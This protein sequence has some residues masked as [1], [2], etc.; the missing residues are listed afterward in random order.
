MS[1]PFVT[2]HLGAGRHSVN[3]EKPLRKLCKAS[4]RHGMEL[5]NEGKSSQEVAIEVCKLLELSE[6]TN[7]GYGS[8]LNFDGEVECDAGIMESS[9][10]LGASVC[11][12][13]GVTNPIEIAG[14]LLRDLQNEEK[15]PL[16]RVRPIMLVGRGAEKYAERKGIEGGKDLIS[17]SALT[18]FLTWRDIYKKVMSADLTL[19]AEGVQ[20]TEQDLIQDTVGVICGDINGII[21]VATSS[22]GTTLKTPGRVGPAAM[23]G[24]GLNITRKD[25]RTYAVCISG[26]GEDIIQSQVARTLCGAAMFSDI[27]LNQYLTRINEQHALQRPPLYFGA[28]GVCAADD[29]IELVYLHTTEAFVVGHQLGDKPVTVEI[30]RN[31]SVGALA[32]GGC[33]HRIIP[34]HS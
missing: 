22:G 27:D 31:S 12:V 26:T 5:L 23:L 30:S 20:V 1:T 17:Q 34:H 19:E 6:L 16:G 29:C 2:I 4:C 32:L 15:D 3:S 7:A 10:L 33:S 9:R 13:T 28:L 21:S 18:Y 25:N 24:T 8:Q 14:H 11:A